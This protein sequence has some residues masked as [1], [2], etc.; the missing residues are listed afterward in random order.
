MVKESA[1]LATV[2]RSL[3]SSRASPTFACH[4]VEHGHVERKPGRSKGEVSLGE[5]EP[6]RTLA[7]MRA[8]PMCNLLSKFSVGYSGEPRTHCIHCMLLSQI[9]RQ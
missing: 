9:L 7:L 2:R 3:R 6:P 4:L 8:T 1:G 5:P